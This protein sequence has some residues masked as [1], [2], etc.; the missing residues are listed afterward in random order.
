MSTISGE[1]QGI[2]FSTL[3]GVGAVFLVGAF[4]VFI[5]TS[6]GSP[7]LIAAGVLAIL[8]VTCFGAAEMQKRRLASDIHDSRP[9][10]VMSDPF[11]KEWPLNPRL[12]RVQGWASGDF[13]TTAVSGTGEPMG[14]IDE[15]EKIHTVHLHVANKPTNSASKEVAKAVSLTIRYSRDGILIHE[16]NG[17]WST[18][19]QNIPYEGTQIAS[20]HDLNAN[21][22]NPDICDVAIKYLSDNECFAMDDTVQFHP[23]DWRKYPLGPEPVDVEITAHQSGEDDTVTNWLLTHDGVGGILHLKPRD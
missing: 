5:A 16:V 13:I 20:A 21:V 12:D 7:R 19:A 3:R 11:V 17:R 4:T 14:G 10:I 1:P 2:S 18:D 9:L 6:K 23:N 15:R 8:A 22:N